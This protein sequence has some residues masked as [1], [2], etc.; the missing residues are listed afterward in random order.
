MASGTESAAVF[1]YTR[2]LAASARM[3]LVLVLAIS[4]VLHAALLSRWPQTPTP[5]SPV[6]L[7]I[8]LD[9][10]PAPMFRRPPPHTKVSR[11]SAEEMQSQPT[12]VR[13]TNERLR[14]LFE[15]TR[16]DIRTGIEREHGSR[17]V[18]PASA[19]LPELPALGDGHQRPEGL[20]R[21]YRLA[22]GGIRYEHGNRNGKTTIW[23]CPEP[24]PNESFAL[25]L[26]RTGY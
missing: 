5:V 8:T 12:N 6:V 11:P 26:C 24:N 17:Q 16:D 15:I 21:S 1:A 3:R 25:N 14:S 13:E 4:A 2:M 7:E 22:N 10:S 18:P 20:V 9:T 19:P 23:E